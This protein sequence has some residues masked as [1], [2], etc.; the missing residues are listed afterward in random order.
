MI[1]SL[2]QHTAMIY[3]EAIPQSIVIVSGLRQAHMSCQ[4]ENTQN[5]HKQ[6]CPV[7]EII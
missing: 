1:A 7:T 4:L 5:M 6:M 2:P 3:C